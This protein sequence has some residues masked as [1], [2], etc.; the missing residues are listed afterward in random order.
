MAINLYILILISP[1]LVIGSVFSGARSATDGQGSDMWSISLT[2][3]TTDSEPTE[4]RALDSVTLSKDLKLLMSIDSNPAVDKSVL[5][6]TVAASYLQ[7]FRR[8]HAYIGEV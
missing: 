7:I 2:S 1:E 4:Y 8:S 6:D 5:F 3:A